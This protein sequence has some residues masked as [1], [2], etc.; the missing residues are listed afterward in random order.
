[1]AFVPKRRMNRWQK[2][3]CNHYKISQQLTRDFVVRI[4]KSRRHFEYRLAM[5]PS[6]SRIQH[7][8]VVDWVLEQKDG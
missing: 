1:M 5:L 6:T 3:I 7:Q 4:A 2:V 8:V